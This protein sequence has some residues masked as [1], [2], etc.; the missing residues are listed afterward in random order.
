MGDGL[1]K[2]KD[3]VLRFAIWLVTLFRVYVVYFP[4][5]I[6]PWL[7]TGISQR[8]KEVSLIL[9]SLI[10]SIFI[11]QVL[12]IYNS[13]YEMKK[14]RFIY[15]CKKL[16]FVQLL[17]V[18]SIPLIFAYDEVIFD[19][20]EFTI[21][22]LGILFVMVVSFG[23]YLLYRKVFIGSFLGKGQTYKRNKANL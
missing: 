9:V 18:L 21:P 14:T 16:L 20:G 15:W 8:P 3:L 17:Y 13:K 5:I 10:V 1:R 6:V 22:P 19:N 2:I 4:A 12:P 7:M 23:I 11:G